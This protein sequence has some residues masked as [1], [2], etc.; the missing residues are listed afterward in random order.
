MQTKRNLLVAALLCV[1]AVAVWLAGSLE[2]SEKTYEIQP[3]VTVGEYR[4]DAARAIDAYERLMERNMD[5]TERSL[6]TIDRDIQGLY[7]KLDLMDVKLD[8][9]SRR[10]NGIEKALG[11]KQLKAPAVKDKKD[12]SAEG[13]KKGRTSPSPVSVR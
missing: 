6:N 13:P 5:L 7:R 2:G 12:T 11:I 9:L 4:T 1:C 10:L 3:Q 8:A